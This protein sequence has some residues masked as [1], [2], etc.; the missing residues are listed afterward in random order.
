MVTSFDPSQ[1]RSSTSNKLGMDK[2]VYSKPLSE[3]LQQI[4]QTFRQRIQREQSIV[5]SNQ[6]LL[7]TIDNS[8]DLRHTILQQS[9]RVAS[10]SVRP[11][12]GFSC[13]RIMLHRVQAIGHTS[14]FFG[15]I[16]NYA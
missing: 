2:F 5:N 6:G 16:Q 11:E 14:S 8:H 10:L 15:W 9:Q 12:V 13:R 4:V 7:A 3:L 1:S